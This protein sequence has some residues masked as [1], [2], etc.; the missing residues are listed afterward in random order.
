[1]SWLP[2]YDGPGPTRV[3]CLGDSIMTMIWDEMFAI[4]SQDPFQISGAMYPGTCTWQMHDYGWDDL[5]SST[6]PRHVVVVSGTND[7]GIPDM[8]WSGM[9]VLAKQKELIDSFPP[10]TQIHWANVYQFCPNHEGV[11]MQAHA[12]GFNAGLAA[13]AA[14]CPNLH[15]VDWNA[16]TQWSWGQGVNLLMSDGVHP[17]QA[18][19]SALCAEFVKSIACHP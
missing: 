14:Q 11:S 15:V 2:T 3:A 16:L 13:W 8:F 7:S 6:C 12:A 9:V 4:Y 1:M 10:T 19:Q 17:N 18:G 5:A